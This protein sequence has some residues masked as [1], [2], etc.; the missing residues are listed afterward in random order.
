MK[1]LQCIFPGLHPVNTISRPFL[2][3]NTAITILNVYVSPAIPLLGI[4]PQEIFASVREEA[5]ANMF[6]GTVFVNW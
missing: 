4:Y 3:G 6:T 5:W 1:R 2:D